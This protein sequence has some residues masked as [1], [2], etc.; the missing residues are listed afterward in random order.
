MRQQ[1]L[2]FGEVAELYDRAR[3]G[4]PEAL[5]DDVIS[6]A[7]GDGPSLRALVLR[8]GCGR[9]PGSPSPARR[10]RGSSP[11]GFGAARVPGEVSM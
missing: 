4:Y 3:A 2:V 5:I 7:G 1:R 10:R 9:A 8:S 6:F 11:S